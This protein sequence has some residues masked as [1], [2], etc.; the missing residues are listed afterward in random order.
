MYRMK[1]EDLRTVTYLIARVWPKGQVSSKGTHRGEGC[2]KVG[3]EIRVMSPSTK[4]KDC[5]LSPE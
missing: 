2:V 3:P 4:D 5:W 1:I